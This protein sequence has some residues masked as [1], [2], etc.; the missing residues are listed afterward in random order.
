MTLTSPSE[1]TC[2]TRAT[3]LSGGPTG[4]FQ[5]ELVCPFDGQVN[6]G[7]EVLGGGRIKPPGRPTGEQVWAAATLTLAGAVGCWGCH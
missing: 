5:K 3:G 6:R 2:H 1:H 4:L 7:Q